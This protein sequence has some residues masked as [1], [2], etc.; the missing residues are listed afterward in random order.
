M[1]V[2]LRAKLQWA[3]R[4]KRKS[5]GLGRRFGAINW[6]NYLWL[7]LEVELKSEEEDCKQSGKIRVE[8]TISQ[9]QTIVIPCS[10]TIKLALKPPSLLFKLAPH[11][12]SWREMNR[13]WTLKCELVN[14]WV[15]AS[16]SF[17]PLLYQ[18]AFW[19]EFLITKLWKDRERTERKKKRREE[20]GRQNMARWKISF[21]T[22]EALGSNSSEHT[23]HS[24]HSDF[25]QS[26]VNSHTAPD[27][28]IWWIKESSSSNYHFFRLLFRSGETLKGERRALS[29]KATRKMSAK[30]QGNFTRRRKL[31]KSKQILIWKAE[32][33]AKNWV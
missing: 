3:L 15:N 27:V 23:F 19:N 24:S 10:H 17:F 9:S 14:C 12:S 4:L 28:S 6:K 20:G 29:W 30:L 32:A 26:E 2:R 13:S 11:D 21:D 5:P 16:N 33:K 7:R 18:E 25:R 31:F 22:Q 8:K 1:T